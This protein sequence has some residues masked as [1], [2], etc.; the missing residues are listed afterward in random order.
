[1]GVPVDPKDPRYVAPNVSIAEKPREEHPLRDRVTAIEI[2]T[3]FSQVA[4]STD[5][6][7]L[8]VIYGPELG[9]RAPLGPSPFE[10][11]R[12]SRAD[13]P[14]DQES[15]SR[16]HA[17][18]TWDG[19][20]HVIEDLG[21]TN[22][23]FVNDSNAKRSPLKDGDQ[24]KL[25]R[26]I[27]KYMAGDNI[28][29]N[30]H[31]EIYRLMTTDALT[32]THNRRYFNEA[33]EREY[34][35]SLRYRRALSL[36]LF[37]IDHFK[38]I[39]DTYGHVAGDSVL[40]QLSLVVKPRLRQQDVLARIGGEEFAILLPEVDIDGARVAGEKVRKLVE[41]AR[42]LVDSKEFG[43]TVSVGLAAFDAR[44]TAPQ[45][46]YEAADK[47]LYAAKNAGRNRVVG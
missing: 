40:R 35:R 29:A 39:N 13:L 22:G 12:S 46:L 33:L 36:V 32:Q 41:A 15:I 21:S 27:L 8:V 25:G 24:I 34:N 17:R 44:M 3:T 38:Q 14:I 16:H 30:Y 26:S 31:E 42:F 47:S 18:I 43:C 19:T 2:S 45:L 1:M 9:K 28:E 4:T 7:C 23:T 37:D 10:I 11:G 20:R 6:A 5:R